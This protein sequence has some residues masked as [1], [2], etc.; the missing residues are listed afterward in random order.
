MIDDQVVEVLIT[1]DPTRAICEIETG[2]AQT[3]PE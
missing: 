1:V 3:R 2:I